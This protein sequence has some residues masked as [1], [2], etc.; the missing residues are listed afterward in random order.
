MN[1]QETRN[2]LRMLRAALEEATDTENFDYQRGRQPSKKH[3]DFVMR[4]KAGIEELEKEL[5]GSKRNPRYLVSRDGNEVGIFPGFNALMAI[6]AARKIYGPGKYSSV[7]TGE[8]MFIG[9]G[10]LQAEERLREETAARAAQKAAAKR[11]KIK[12]PR[13]SRKANPNALDNQLV[14][15]GPQVLK[16]IRIFD[17]YK[18][19]D[20]ESGYAR[21]GNVIRYF[22]KNKKGIWTSK[23]G[24][25]GI[26]Y[27]ADYPWNMVSVHHKYLLDA[28]GHGDI[29][30]RNPTDR[31]ALDNQ[32]VVI[33]RKAYQGVRVFD[34]YK[35]PEGLF[36]HGLARIGNEIRWLERKNKNTWVGRPGPAG[37]RNVPWINQQLLIKE[38]HG[39]L[40]QRN[41]L[42]KSAEH[43]IEVT[44][45]YR[46]GGPNYLSPWQRA[47]A[48]GQEELFDTGIQML[49]RVAE[50]RAALFATRNPGATKRAYESGLKEATAAQLARLVRVGLRVGLTLAEIKK[51]VDAT[52]RFTAA[53]I[54]RAMDQA[55]SAEERLAKKQNPR[56]GSRK[57]GG[58]TNRKSGKNNFP[59][60]TLHKDGIEG[61]EIP[62]SSVPFGDATA[63]QYAL[64][65]IEEDDPEPSVFRRG[66]WQRGT[67]GGW[68]WETYPNKLL[69]QNP[70]PD[71]LLQSGVNIQI[72]ATRNERARAFVE[73]LPNGA[74]K[75]ALLSGLSK[76]MD[77]LMADV[78]VFDMPD[79]MGTIRHI[80]ARQIP[81]KPKWGAARAQLLGFF[82]DR[83][84]NPS[85]KAI[86]QK[87]NGRPSR[88]SRNVAAPAGTPRDL[89]QLGRLRTIKTVDGRT[90]RFPGDR[91]P[92][93]AADSRGKL[94]IVGGQY[95]ANPAGED[96][97]EIDLVEYQTS[98]PHLGHD[99]ETIYYHHMGEET[100]ERPT[101]EITP[102]GEL[103]IHGGA[104]R[105]EPEGLVN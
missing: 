80:L 74:L 51:D 20:F 97:G 28:E 105:I 88:R 71:Q 89:A 98:K 60:L 65:Y 94:H 73:S 21:I 82:D 96:C 30:K 84:S 44:R 10:A 59:L 7:K 54:D 2:A 6:N 1:K 15:I 4:L 33:G 48:I 14:M 61:I 13:K 63:W 81:N 39:D 69:K 43:P 27:D 18:D 17:Y 102:A 34:I 55:R 83:E 76:T 45:H 100:G 66:A 85:V 75:K 58:A 9:R 22:E 50:R 72:F 87:F 47:M 79:Y 77:A 70:T 40:I 92:F 25:A 41:P 36:E 103:V 24:K 12:T 90:W 11:D 67:Y 32:L 16:G 57:Y 91:A 95:R 104:Y 19:P 29:M 5:K 99:N 64:G 42:E 37:V 49:P 52:G 56:R 8:A 3:A 46:S 35:Q 68:R 38:G 53:Q 86:Y 101:L 23:P 26:W 62:A 78:T 31:P 93:L